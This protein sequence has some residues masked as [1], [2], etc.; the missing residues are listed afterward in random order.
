MVVPT[1]AA[2]SPSI[3]GSWRTDDGAAIIDIRHCG[4]ALCGKIIKIL[5][6]NAPPNDINNPDP[7]KRSQPLHPATNAFRVFGRFDLHQGRRA[8]LQAYIA[9][10]A[11]IVIRSTQLVSMDHLRALRDHR[12]SF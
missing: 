3:F 6:R 8:G 7:K 5:D 10:P 2:P 1:S 12:I 9:T 11:P 4:P